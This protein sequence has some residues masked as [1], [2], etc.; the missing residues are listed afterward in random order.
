MRVL[1]I[2][3]VAA[4]RIMLSRLLRRLIPNVELS[5]CSNGPKGIA[6]LAGKQEF[7]L[8]FLDL[9][10]EDQ[11]GFS[12]L[13]MLREGGESSPVIAM[14][15]KDLDEQRD[16][17]QILGVRHCL[18]KPLTLGE[19]SPILGSYLHSDENQVEKVLIVEDDSFISM[20]LQ[21]IIMKEGFECDVA[22]NG[23]EA[24]RRV[25]S[26]SYAA[27]ISDVRMPYMS[28][29]EAGGIM[30]R[31]CPFLPIIYLTAAPL[32]PSSAKEIEMDG[33][34]VL[35]KP[36]DRD[37]L[38][39]TLKEQIQIK[40]DTWIAALQPDSQEETKKSI[41][42]NINEMMSKFAPVHFLKNK[43]SNA[44]GR[45]LKELTPCSILEVEIHRFHELVEF[46]GH[47][48][49]FRFFNSYF[50]VVEFIIEEFGG[51]VIHLSNGSLQA[52]FPLFKERF[53]NN[54]LH[55]ALS[56]QDQINIY[57]KGR[58]RAGYAPIR[59]GC[60]LSTGEVALGIYGSGKRHNLGAFGGIMTEVQSFQKICRHH[61]CEIVLSESTFS[62][63]EGAELFPVRLLGN[64]DLRGRPEKIGAYE[65][66]Y[67][68]SL[69]KRK[70]DFT[71]IQET[72][73]RTVQYEDI[74][75]SAGEGLDEDVPDDGRIYI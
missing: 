18:P 22:T 21:R 37:V 4:N 42:E 52:I 15:G 49:S 31:E 68:A 7:D 63:L 8:V 46:M 69:G 45:G 53:S 58:Q 2:E 5:L 23:F 32:S 26:Q 28:G 29:I 6:A 20:L 72:L 60:A 36:V 17:T 13:Q 44:L 10:L 55:A 51:E 43:S 67:T 12:I 65:A 1:V 59:V 62:A 27:V 74:K 70:M 56:V 41:P 24:I 9:E 14:T 35:E 40:K 75:S 16:A 30:K 64:F 11:A 57:N 71:E 19:L 39:K 47:E 48:N 54:A 3:S 33:D 66:F 25:H 38:I 50:E 61:G 73:V 34:R